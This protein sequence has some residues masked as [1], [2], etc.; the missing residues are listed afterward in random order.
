MVSMVSVGYVSGG[1]PAPVLDP[2]PLTPLVTSDLSRVGQSALF[3]ENYGFTLPYQIESTGQLGG[4]DGLPRALS[5]GSAG[6]SRGG[7]SKRGESRVRFGAVE[8]LAPL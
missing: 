6:G 2:P 3:E 1:L 5:R 8:E 7:G 4:T